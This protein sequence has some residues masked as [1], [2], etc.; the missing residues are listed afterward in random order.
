MPTRRSATKQVVD[1]GSESV[2]RKPAQWERS[3]PTRM[4]LKHDM[5]VTS[6]PL[7]GR[8]GSDPG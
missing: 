1:D 8:T 4:F 2:E 7:P 5:N 6:S 3:I